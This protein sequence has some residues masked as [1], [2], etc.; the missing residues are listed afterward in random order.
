MSD[1]LRPHE[2]QHARLGKKRPDHVLKATVIRLRSRIRT[3]AFCLQPML[4]HH[5]GPQSYMRETVV[6]STGGGGNGSG[7]KL[8]DRR[9]TYADMHIPEWEVGNNADIHRVEVDKFLHIPIKEHCV[10]LQNQLFWLYLIVRSIKGI[11]YS[12]LRTS[13]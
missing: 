7:E 1:S 4:E 8:N 13:Q 12:W 5:D 10:A 6:M 9:H 2:S 3:S 11:I